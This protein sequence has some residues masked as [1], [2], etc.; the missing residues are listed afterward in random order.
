[1][2][3]KTALLDSAETFARSKGFDAF[4]YADLSEKVGI[5]KASI[6]HHF[7]TKADLGLMLISRY[8]KNFGVALGKIAAKDATAA[9]KLSAYL[10]L[11]RKA[12]KGG[13]Q[14][15]L[16][17]AFSAG[18][19]SFGD[20]V[21]SELKAFHSESVK[22]LTALFEEGRDDLSILGVNDPHAEA[23]ACLALVEGAQLMARAAKDLSKFDE[24]VS[25]LRDRATLDASP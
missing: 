16:C 4:S 2:D 6:H 9:T 21:L 1:M 19:D 13:A 7:P 18:R 3:T 15:C 20:A 25:L 10:T 22:W 11:Y 5:R 12:L 14:V 8:R 24:A 17:V 23:S